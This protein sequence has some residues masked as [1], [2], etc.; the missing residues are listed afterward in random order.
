MTG[1]DLHNRLVASGKHIP[2]IL[3]TAYPSER[4]RTR[5]L[6]AGV[7]GYLSKPFNEDELL[8]CIR[9]ALDNRPSGGRES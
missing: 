6:Q 9:L 7:T 1:L 2:T 3:I 5:A 8:A 4:A